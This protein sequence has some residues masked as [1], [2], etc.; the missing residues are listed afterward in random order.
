MTNYMI[1]AFHSY[2]CIA[3]MFCG[4]SFS[5]RVSAQLSTST[6][7]PMLTTPSPKATMMDRFGNY[8][9]S[10]Y[11][12]LVDVTIPVFT[13]EI[14]GIVVP[15]EFRYHAS[16]LK[17]DDLPMELGYGWTLLAGGTVSYSARGA[18]DVSPPNGYRQSPFI[19]LTNDIHL[20]DA[21]GSADSHQKWLGYLA[22]GGKPNGTL[23]GDYYAD[24]EYDVF[25]YSFLNHSGQFYTLSGEPE[26]QVPKNSLK[27]LP[28]SAGATIIDDRGISY[29]FEKME[30]DYYHRNET[31]YLKR[32]IS[33]D[34][35]DT[36]EF[37]YRTF[38]QGGGFEG[39]VMRPVIDRTYRVIEREPVETPA[40]KQTTYEYG[41]SLQTV[42][43]A[44]YPPVLTSIQYSGGSVE[45][46]YQNETSSHSLKEIHVRTGTGQLVKSVNLIKPRVDWL[47]EVEFRDRTNT[48]VYSYKFGYNS[49]VS[50][51]EG[52]DYWGYYNGKALAG[53]SAGHVPNFTIPIFSAGSPS[54]TEPHQIPGIDRT[55]NQLY[56]ERG[57]LNQVTY[58]TGGRT[59]FTY[60]PHRSGGKTYGGL[61]IKEI[62]NYD[63]GGTLLE[64]KWYKYGAGE[65]GEGRAAFPISDPTDTYFSN[66]FC[67]HSLLINSI[68]GSGSNQAHPGDIF[69]IRQY[70]AFPKVSYFT[71]G[72]S[73]VYPV[74]TEYSGT[75]STSN[76]KTVYEYNDVPAQRIPTMRGN[77][78]DAKYKL[79]SLINGTLR[80]KTVY[81]SSNQA[82]YSL[83]NNYR[84]IN[85]EQHLNLRVV[86]YADI[87]GVEAEIIKDRF[88]EYPYAYGY[89]DFP[90]TLEGSLY[91]YFN[92]YINTG[93]L[94]LET[95][96]E[97][98]DGVTK[99]TR[100]SGY[101]QYG[102]PGQMAMYDSKGDSMI[103]K[104]KY[105]NDFA[106]VEPY[107][108]MV[109]KQILAPV[110]EEAQY[111][112]T[113][114]LYKQ[115]QEYKKWGSQLYAP[116]YIKQQFG[117]A[118]PVVRL[119]YLGYNPQG[120]PMS[121]V[122]NGVSNTSYLWSY[123]GRYLVAEVRNSVQADI[124]YAGFESEGKGNWTYSGA[125]A[126]DATA[127]TG[128]RVYVLT[129]SN[130]LQKTGLTSTRSYLLTYWAKSTSATGISGGTATAMRSKGGWTQYRRLVSGVTSVTLSG[131]VA[132]DDVRLHPV[133]ASMDSYTYDPLVG[134]TSH[135]D[136]SGAVFYYEY[137]DFGRLRSVRDLNGHLTEDYNYHYDN[138]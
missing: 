15:V 91:D 44:F 18:S 134:M 138:Q 23:S 71:S 75:G 2:I 19:R 124:A 60:E 17:Y 56:M 46:T 31:Y 73:V 67:S 63:K 126:A 55:P 43:K 111:K 12:G 90:S 1:K 52:V 7:F 120:K 29:Y 11:T 105:P 22:A 114:F 8:P 10:F 99:T 79:D 50:G 32:I 66:D 51:L 110:L 68:I 83:I 42:S 113:T 57:I 119:Q 96:T 27:F 5:L 131:S 9:V 117:T 127:P 93:L 89:R 130:N 84:V 61:R 103:T 3:V 106:T 6:S 33:A 47:D 13:V 128:K 97:T 21:D 92:Y 77:R 95:S 82:V 54:G 37:V 26:I 121:V 53:N 34:Q 28:T 116:E 24:G 102:Q 112:N 38:S 39:G 87:T 62:R 80:K 35:A 101:N 137:D 94:M 36:V 30:W 86:D 123:D 135:T 81:N 115:I 100:Y 136:V 70:Y 118:A 49:T 16:G 48:K 98:R 125:P 76:G 133:E 78:S 109:T 64:K 41:G 108:T 122:N 74:V 65:T 4:F 107:K 88:S 58:P 59:E 45:F 104:Y 132:V 72:S 85:A 129:G 14:N 69:R 20:N 40:F 25:S